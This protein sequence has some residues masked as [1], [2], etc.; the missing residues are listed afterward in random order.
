MEGLTN[1]LKTNKRYT[2]YIN[3]IKEMNLTDEQREAIAKVTQRNLTILG[4]RSGTKEGTLCW[5]TLVHTLMGKLVPKSNM[6]GGS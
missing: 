3:T 5:Y 4:F 1:A 6:E 2:K